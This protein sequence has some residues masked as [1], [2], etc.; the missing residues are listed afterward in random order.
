MDIPED[1]IYEDPDADDE[2]DLDVLD[3]RPI[4]Y[5]TTTVPDPYT[6]SFNPDN[7]IKLTITEGKSELSSACQ[8]WIKFPYSVFSIG[9]PG[10]WAG[11]GGWGGPWG[12]ATRNVDPTDTVT[13]EYTVTTNGYVTTEPTVI[14]EQRAADGDIFLKNEGSGGAGTAWGYMFAVMGATAVGV[15]VML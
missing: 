8:Q 1:T 9:G 15:M 14:S 10:G 7:F 11:Y 6:T 5:H 13:V 4:H 2:D 12:M 3:R